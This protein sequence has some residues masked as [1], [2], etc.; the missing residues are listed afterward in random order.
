MY[1]NHKPIIRGT[2]EGIWRRIKLI[3]FTVTIPEPERDPDLPEK[4][5]A[6]LPGILAW[7]VAGCKAWQREGLQ[8]PSEVNAATIAYRAEQDTLAAFLS[9]CCIIGTG[10]KVTSGELFDVYQKWGGELNR[11]RFS[12]AMA[13]RG[14]VTLGRDGAGRAL[15]HDIGLVEPQ[16]ER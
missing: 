10:Y 1:G 3:P 16:D 4:L 8:T 15:Y 7:A 11:R 9:E 12:S 6:E 13:E 14:F 2:D 5:K